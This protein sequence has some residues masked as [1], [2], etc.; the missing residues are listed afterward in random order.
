VDD[1]PEP[2]EFYGVLALQNMLHCGKNT[3]PRKLGDPDGRLR[4]GCMDAPLWLCDRALDVAFKPV[5]FTSWY[6]LPEAARMVGVGRKI[7]EKIAPFN[8]AVAVSGKLWVARHRQHVKLWSEQQCYELRRKIA[9]GEIYVHW[10]SL[11]KPKLGVVV[12]AP[13]HIL[14]EDQLKDAKAHRQAYPMLD[15]A[16]SL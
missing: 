5:P 16:A 13:R 12:A 4:I 11:T 10:R 15:L 6:T 2:I 9:S 14:V 8:P 3:I 1:K 7:F